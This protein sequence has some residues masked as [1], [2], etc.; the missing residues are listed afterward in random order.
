MKSQVCCKYSVLTSTIQM[1]KGGCNSTIMCRCPSLVPRLLHRKTAREPGR[2]YHVPRDVACVV[3]IIE[4]LPTQS[5]SKYCP[6]IYRCCW[7]FGCCWGFTGRLYMSYFVYRLQYVYIA[8]TGT[9]VR[10]GQGF[11]ER[12]RGRLVHVCVAETHCASWCSM[13]RQEVLRRPL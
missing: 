4:L 11:N 10:P 3:L 2:F 13:S 5:D 9:F 6:A 12:S 7:S 8:S 1:N